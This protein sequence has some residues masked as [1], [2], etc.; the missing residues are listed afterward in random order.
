MKLDQFTYPDT[1]PK[2]LLLAK[3]KK[4]IPSLKTKPHGKRGVTIR[5]KPPKLLTNK[6]YFQESLANTGLL[7]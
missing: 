7:V 5:F 6:W 1:Y 4:L 2:N 3:H